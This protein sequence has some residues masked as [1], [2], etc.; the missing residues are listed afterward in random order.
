[1]DN[2]VVWVQK[3]NTTKCALEFLNRFHFVEMSY[4]FGKSLHQIYLQKFFQIFA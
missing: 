2:A 1:M 4:F 3:K